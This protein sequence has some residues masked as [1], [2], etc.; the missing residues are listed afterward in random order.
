MIQCGATEPRAEPGSVPYELIERATQDI[1]ETIRGEQA[2]L[3]L[4]TPLTATAQKIYNWIN[5]RTLW[6]ANIALDEDQLTRL[7]AVLETVQLRPYE[8]DPLLK[9]IIKTYEQDAE[10]VRLITDLDAYFAENG[11]YLQSDVDLQTAQAIKEEDLRLVC[12]ERLES[13]R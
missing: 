6:E 9:G 8:R 1:L 11:L 3:R 12:F 10:F 13:A 7:N 2:R 4:R 5:R